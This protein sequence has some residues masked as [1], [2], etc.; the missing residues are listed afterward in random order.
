MTTPSIEVIDA[1]LTENEK[2]TENLH[3]RVGGSPGQA[4]LEDKVIDIFS[5]LSSLEFW[6]NAWIPRLE[7]N[8]KKPLMQ[9]VDALEDWQNKRDNE[10]K[11]RR[12]DQNSIKIAIFLMIVSSL[13]DIVRDFILP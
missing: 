3:L 7:G 8:G 9:R 13:W 2:K 10:V 11:E 1:R 4:G 12:S 6:R 5:R